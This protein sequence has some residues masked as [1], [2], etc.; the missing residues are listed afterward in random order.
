[1]IKLVFKKKKEE[2]KEEKLD[3][4]ISERFAVAHVK[5]VLPLADL[6]KLLDQGWVLISFTKPYAQDYVYYFTKVIS[7]GQKT[8]QQQQ[9]TY[10]VKIDGK[11]YQ[12]T[13]DTEEEYK[14][15]IDELLASKVE[16]QQ[17]S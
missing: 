4:V 16:V 11:E 14:Q 15:K 12:I 13:A 5:E 9:T 3:L 6:E 10:T 17:I 7:S 1:M 2:K 8:M